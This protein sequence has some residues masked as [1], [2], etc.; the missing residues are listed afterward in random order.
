MIVFDEAL[1]SGCFSESEKT[2]KVLG[3]LFLHR[4]GGGYSSFL[5]GQ[6]RIIARC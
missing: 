1:A 2:R 5:L 4:G 3:R 6:Q